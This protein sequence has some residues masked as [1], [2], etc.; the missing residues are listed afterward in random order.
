MSFLTS[1]ISYA[2]LGTLIAA[3][4]FYVAALAAQQRELHDRVL[5]LERELL[6]TDRGANALSQ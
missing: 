4:G 1:V 2:V 6:A 3:L 5:Q